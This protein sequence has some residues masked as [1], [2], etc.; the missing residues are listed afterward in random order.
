MGEAGGDRSAFIS[1]VGTFFLLL[2]ILLVILFIASDISRVDRGHPCA[3]SQCT[4]YPAELSI[5]V[6]SGHT[7]LRAG[8]FHEAQVR[9]A[10]IRG[11]AL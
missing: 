8:D 11:E 1:R 6:L 2:G 10:T 9:P 3:T 4:Q 5:P 7:Y